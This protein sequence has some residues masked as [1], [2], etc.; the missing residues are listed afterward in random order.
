MMI[1][2]SCCCCCLTFSLILYMFL[3]RRSC[4]FLTSAAWNVF[5]G[6][7]A[8]FLSSLKP[9]QSIEMQQVRWFAISELSF[10]SNGPTG[11][12]G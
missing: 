11:G 2:T 10:P 6:R 8:S 1:F 9:G 12:A 4:I 5:L 3:V 7:D